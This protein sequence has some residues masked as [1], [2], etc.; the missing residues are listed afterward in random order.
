MARGPGYGPGPWRT[1]SPADPGQDLALASNPEE[2]HP[3]GELLTDHPKPPLELSTTSGITSN[4][5]EPD[6]PIGNR[7]IC[8]K[9]FDDG[10]GDTIKAGDEFSER[11]ILIAAGPLTQGASLR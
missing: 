10:Q 4:L 3:A 9:S 8:P 5:D 2:P 6:P 11:W 1:L 7:I